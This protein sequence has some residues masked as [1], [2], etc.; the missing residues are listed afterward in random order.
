MDGDVTGGE[1]ED[2][3]EKFLSRYDAELRVGKQCNNRVWFFLTFENTKS[4]LCIHSVTVRV[5]TQE[6][7]KHF[8]LLHQH[9][10]GGS[11]P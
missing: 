5:V 6:H 2:G 3:G 8:S 1:Q 4:D 9:F 7:G 10:R 11:K